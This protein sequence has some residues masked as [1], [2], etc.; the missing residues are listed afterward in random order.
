MALDQKK[1][2][3]A[4]FVLDQKSNP[5]VL[6][7][8]IL[9][10]PTQLHEIEATLRA[11]VSVVL[12]SVSGIK[13]F[14][15]LRGSAADTNLLSEI[16]NLVSETDFQN[17]VKVALLANDEND[18][19]I[20]KLLN[21]LLS[22][23][24][25]RMASDLHIDPDGTALKLRLRLDGVMT[26]FAELDPR[27]AQMLV[28]RIKILANM[29]ITERRKPQDGR[30][31]TVFGGQA[32]DIRVA[33]LPTRG[34]ERVVLR[35]FK[36]TLTKMLVSDTGLEQ[37]HVDALMTAV[38]AQSGLLLVCGP[39]GSGK[40][41]TIYS[42]LNTLLGRGLNIMTV[43][44]P[45]E[46]EIPSI[47]QTQVNE[48][49]DFSFSEG[50]RALL[51]NDPDVILVGE[52]RDAQTAEIAIRAAMTGHLV[53]S[54]VHANSPSGAIKR[55][56]NLGVDE[57]LLLDSLLGV[58]SQRLI[59][60]Y[61]ES[62]RSSSITTAGHSSELPVPFG[63][64]DNCYSSGFKGRQPVMSHLLLRGRASK[65]LNLLAAADLAI[66]TMEV[67]A[68]SLHQRGMTARFEVSKV[69]Y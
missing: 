21:N 65:T 53:I 55:L 8:S 25:N 29:D 42:L 15:N 32:V 62:C 40:T 60:I 11:K 46:V 23:A 31:T 61:C 35:F 3:S 1:L 22:V 64:C 63:G 50:L 13:A 45:V 59:R 58:F 2:A 19:P 37:V 48:Q 27:V 56:I 5:A 47:V 26:D 6:H 34:G 18:A 67:E 7:C 41:T 10:S 39:T 14:E 24:I 33:T 12:N 57:T 51:R 4:G 30:L 38:S 52:I 16:D 28:A 20:K 49:I 36:N 9:P 69:R 43:E 17:S 54:T 44:D 68:Q 66:N